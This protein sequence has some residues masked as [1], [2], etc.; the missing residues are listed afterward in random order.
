MSVVAAGAWSLQRPALDALLPR[1]VERDEVAAAG[2]LST[3]QTTV[4]ML[5]GPVV[6]GLLVASA[7]LAATYDIDVATFGISLALLRAMQP[8]PPPPD[9][10]RPSLAGIAEACAT[11]AAGPS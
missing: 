11:P 9:A 3:F 4:G 8:V 10:R 6:G 7:G 1:L 2:A 5:A